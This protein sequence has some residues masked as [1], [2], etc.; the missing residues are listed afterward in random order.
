M[1]R[2][3]CRIFTYWH[4]GFDNAPELVQACQRTMAR[5]TPG[6]SHHFLDAQSVQNWIEPIPVPEC[7]WNRLSL[8]HQ[9]DVIRT[10]LLIRH[11]GVWADPTVLFTRPLVDWLPGKME[12]GV[13][14]FHR[15]GPDR[16]VSNWFI[17]SEAHHPLLTRL[18]EELCRYWANNDFNNFGR[19]M[20]PLASFAARVLNRNLE[21]PRLWLRRPFIR[22]LKAYPYM[23]YHYMLY[24]LI[25]SDPALKS[26]WDRMP[27]L[28][29][30]IPHFAA[31]R[32]LLEPID[33]EAKRFID[34]REAPLFKLSWKL[35]FQDIPPESLLVY[36]LRQ[37]AADRP[38]RKESAS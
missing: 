25:R 19:P 11:G 2:L 31:H 27:K 15:P 38:G 10:Q 35:P 36:L 14:L 29:A 24:D 28:S 18:Y 34:S 23:I 5:Y 32:G 7:T 3:P 20:S 16:A 13:F 4:Q 22:L 21:L 26:V 8:A 6:W 9:S 33:D 37:F 30:D 17:A 1:N 12:A